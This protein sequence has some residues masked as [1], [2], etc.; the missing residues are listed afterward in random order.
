[1][2]TCYSDIRGSCIATANCIILACPHWVTDNADRFWSL[3]TQ[4]LS[5]PLLLSSGYRAS[6][7][8]TL[9]LDSSGDGT[10]CVNSSASIVST[11][12][13]AHHQSDRKPL[14]DDHQVLTSK[15]VGHVRSAL[16][17]VSKYSP[18][19]MDD[20]TTAIRELCEAKCVELLPSSQSSPTEYSSGN[21]SG[22][23]LDEL[24]RAY[25]S[26]PKVPPGRIVDK[27]MWKASAASAMTDVFRLAPRPSCSSRSSSKFAA[28]E[29][30]SDINNQESN[31]ENIEIALKG[32]TLE[33]RQ[34]K[35]NFEFTDLFIR[36]VC[37]DLLHLYRAIGTITD[38]G[39][40]YV[41]AYVLHTSS[42]RIFFSSLHSCSSFLFFLMSL[43]FCR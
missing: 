38:P 23:F 17:N 33:D 42:V 26:H 39:G 2:R 34:N 6:Q 27:T 29:V 37:D 19:A 31:I 32:I 21:T 12:H 5:T 14:D 35:Q 41:C 40:T 22:D 16:K 3:C 4:S 24:L 13:D 15:I 11:N 36:T 20:V 7:R 9:D 25:S 1:M 43:F 28:L 18:S 30:A 8:R 10:V